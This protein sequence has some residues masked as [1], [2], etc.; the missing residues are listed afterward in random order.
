M[1]GKSYIRWFHP[2]R[3]SPFAERFIWIGGFLVCM[4][5]L[6]YLA[7][8]WILRPKLRRF[9]E[10]DTGAAVFLEHVRWKSPLTL[11]LSRLVLAEE[12]ARPQETL[13]FWAEQADCVLSWSR[14]L[15]L[16]VQPERI[17][18]KRAAAELRY[19][20]ESK[21]WNL[22][23]L[24]PAGRGKRLVRIPDIIIQTGRLT[25]QRI[26]GG[27]RQTLATVDFQGQMKQD[28]GVYRVLLE[29]LQTGIFAGSRLEGVWQ[30]KDGRGRFEGS[31]QIRMPLIYIWGNAW[32]LDD[33]RFACSYDSQQFRMEQFSCRLGD[34]RVVFRGQIGGSPDQKMLSAET[35]LENLYLSASSRPDRIVYSEPVLRMMTS[36]L[37]RFLRR[38]QPEGSADA[39]L[40][41]NGPLSDLAQSRLDG[42]IVCRDIAVLDR[43][44]PYRLEHIRGDIEF[45]GR[46]LHLKDLQ[47]QNGAS[48]FTI[49]G[50]ITN[51]GPNA[52][53]QLQV[54]SEK[55]FLTEEIKRALP[56][57]LQRK[58]FE[59]APSGTCGFDYQFTR[60]ANAERFYQSIIRLQGVNCLYDRCPYPLTSLTGTLV[61]EPNSLM[62]QQVAAQSGQ[63]EE[64]RIE[65]SIKN[66]RKAPACD[67]KIT[68]RRLPFDARLR[69][70]FPKSIRQVLSEFEADGVVDLD[71]QVK[72]LYE[73]DKPLPVRVSF[74]AEAERLRWKPFPLD[75]Q[76]VSVQGSAENGRAEWRAAALLP[77]GGSGQLVG[78]FWNCGREPNQPGM[79][80]AFTAEDV[81]LNPAFWT[82]M[83]NTGLYQNVLSE[84]RAEG[85]ADAA[86]RFYLNCPDRD[87]SFTDTHPLQESQ[88]SLTVRLK[89]GELYHPGGGWRTGS[90]S[91]VFSLEDDSFTFSGWR[92]SNVPIREVFSATPKQGV[93]MISSLEPFGRADVQL[94]FLEW[95]PRSSPPLRRAEGRIELH[96]SGFN[97]LAVSGAEG[98]FEGRLRWTKSSLLPEGGGR[99]RLDSANV[100]S[101]L[102][103][104]A[105]GN[106]AVDPNTGFLS[107]R[108]LRAR[109]GPEGRFLAN[110]QMK[111]DEPLLPFEVNAVFEDIPLNRF[112]SSP[113]LR[114]GQ[115]ETSGR[116]RGAADIRG[117]AGQLEDS[118]GRITLEADQLKIGR[119]SLLGKA[120]MV[121][122]LRQADEFLF[123]QLFAEAALK[124]SVIHCERILLAGKNDVYQGQGRFSLKDGTIQMILTA[125]GRRKNQ[126]PTLLTGLAENLGAALAR[127]EI[128]GTLAQPV[129]A[130][131]PLPLL[132]RPF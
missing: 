49:R 106:W 92:I 50:Q 93:R 94:D 126:E 53:I 80:I 39:F 91:G 72:G 122:Q 76:G 14:L 71:V 18:I 102:L 84:I 7:S 9:L 97:R 37:E 38:Y 99:F 113:E 51:F 77:D 60:N 83:E 33:I 66:L 10:A 100:R 121:M 78:C 64:I 56:E 27:K 73:E 61:I 124:G 105:E 45:T 31:G 69:S 19:D 125:F 28:A 130:Q 44:F 101:C 107:V 82:A 5:L 8:D 62:L 15:R 22:N 63:G 24:K 129:I 79:Q 88:I 127:V 81:S 58:W 59:F 13:I 70:A 108:D 6:F 95:T 20:A 114:N 120:L 36:G 96:Q 90:A 109:C 112:S 26:E 42:K 74:A 89:E 43:K 41:I 54:A 32:N 17:R 104:E 118:E 132:P 46:N 123:T 12:A 110:L 52:E 40:R 87:S 3:L 25:V 68:A 47:A 131:I 116:I 23:C 57:S 21:R 103:S 34:G 117:K 2:R 29:A 1:K 55:V 35:E 119:E 16:D 128:S 48:Q 86:G 98:F 11:R 115:L 85:I 4:L 67:L 75:F 65:G 30:P 111:T